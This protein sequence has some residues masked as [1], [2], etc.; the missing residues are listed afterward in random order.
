MAIGVLRR[1]EYPRVRLVMQCKSLQR[2]FQGLRMYVLKNLMLK[3]SIVV[4]KNRRQ[5]ENGDQR[6]GLDLRGGGSK[7]GVWLCT[8]LSR[9]REQNMR[10]LHYSSHHAGG[11]YL[12]HWGWL[13]VALV[14]HYYLSLCMRPEQRPFRLRL[15]IQ[16]GGKGGASIWHLMVQLPTSMSLVLSPSN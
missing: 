9:C 12:V 10:F 15:V 2:T 1:S 8:W 3:L 6:I 4:R 14:K 7:R 16:P 5:S 13:L 11:E